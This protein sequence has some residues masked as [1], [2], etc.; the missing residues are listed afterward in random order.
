[1]TQ[2]DVDWAVGVLARRRATLAP[3]APVYWRPAADAAQRHTE[4][5]AYLLGE[6]G[7]IGFRTENG[8]MAAAPGRQGWTIDDAWLPPGLWDQDGLALWT[9]T[10]EQ[11]GAEPVRFVCPVF[12]PERSAFARD[13][14]LTLVNSWWH[15]E[16]VPPVGGAS[17]VDAEPRLEGASATLVPAPPVY[18]PG[19]PITYLRDVQ[20]ITAITRARTEAGRFGS[21]LVVVDQPAEAGELGQALTEAGFARHC[22]FFAAY[23]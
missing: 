13:R 4:F 8:L 15:A 11:L 6:G 5:L 1:M 20:D 7:G 21:P 3:H 23:G 18:D 10:V 16:V 14:G 9:H 19:G 2:D 12:E 17:A 22:D